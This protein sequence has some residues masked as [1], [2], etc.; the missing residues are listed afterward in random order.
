MLPLVCILLWVVQ[1]TGQDSTPSPTQQFESTTLEPRNFESSDW[2]KA[3]KGIDYRYS[4]EE[5]ENVNEDVGDTLGGEGTLE[6]EKARLEEQAKKLGGRA[7]AFWNTLVKIIFIAFIVVM[8][9]LLIYSIIKGENIFKKK[10]KISRTTS[11]DLEEVETNLADSDLDQFIL[12]AE[13]EGNY[14]LAIRLHYLAIIKAL[15]RKKII[16]YKKNKTNHVYV[17]KVSTTPFGEEFRRA[18]NAF[19]RIWFGQ[20]TFTQ[21]DYQVVKPDFQKW[22]ATAQNLSGEKSSLNLNTP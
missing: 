14:P 8:V 16:R 9:G 5:Q 6:R 21:T 17:T 10:E 22:I 20:N 18:T 2:E 19:E 15:A 1:L 13:K 11:F 7:G 3:T 12:Q 4:T